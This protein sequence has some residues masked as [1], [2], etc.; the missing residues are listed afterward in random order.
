M[1]IESYN[2]IIHYTISE[3]LLLI[4][5]NYNTIIKAIIIIKYLLPSLS[6]SLPCPVQSS[7]V[8]L[9][10]MIHAYGNN[11]SL[12]VSDYHTHKTVIKRIHFIK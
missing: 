3:Q 5:Y 10:G 11:I 9:L 2:S 6:T 8:P 4:K 12:P 7:P 1:Y